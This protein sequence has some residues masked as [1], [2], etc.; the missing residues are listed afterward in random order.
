VQP[1]VD[2]NTHGW[3]HHPKS[4]SDWQGL[5][6]VC[7]GGPRFAAVLDIARRGRCRSVVVENRYVDADFR[8]DYSAFWSRRFDSVPPFTRR[9]HFFRAH[10]GDDELSRLSPAKGYLGYSVL[11]PVPHGDGRVGRTVLAPPLQLR[12]ATMALVRDEVSLFGARLTVTG[13]PFTEQDGEFLRCAHAAIWVC[14]YSAYRRGLVGRRLTAE[15]ADLVPALLSADRNLPSP[16]MK[17]EQVQAVF[18]ATGQ[19]ALRY[20]LNQMPRVPGVE[21]PTP[22]RTPSGAVL[23]PGYWDTRMF[24]VICRYLNSGFPVM[25]A[26]QT[27]AWVIVGW[28]QSQ[29]KIKFVACDDQRGPYEIIDSPFTDHRAPWLAIM[30]PLPPKVFMSG[31]MAETWAHRTFHATGVHAGVPTSW[32]TLAQQLATTPKKV[33]LRTFLRDVR[34]YKATVNGQGRPKEA[35]AALRLARLPHFVWVVEAH[36]RQLRD[37]GQPSVLAEALFDPNSSD[38]RHRPPRRDAL[39]LPGATFITPP[40]DGAPVAHRFPEGPWRSQ[41]A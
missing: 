31:E 29:G 34:D 33:S 8:S 11:R 1:W 13:A 18:D 28:F 30:V 14:H 10:V 6:D 32:T 24:S 9:V 40:D 25:V 37:A 15:L 23:P 17:L 12:N 39:T 26:N 21:I 27:H 36:D 19:P 7:G 16:G 20:G 22:S 38:H 5:V 3:V 2:P 41:L 35:A 4:S